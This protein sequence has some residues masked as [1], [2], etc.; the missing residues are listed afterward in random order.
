MA[1]WATEKAKIELSQKEESVVSLPETELGA[2]DR[3]GEEIY[4]DITVNR[5]SYNELI[6]L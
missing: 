6:A 4:L 3:S 2:R 5:S 1:I